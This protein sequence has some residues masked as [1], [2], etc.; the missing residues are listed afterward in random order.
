VIEELYYGRKLVDTL[1][2]LRQAVVR[3]H[4]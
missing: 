1:V 3:L 4:V 2:G